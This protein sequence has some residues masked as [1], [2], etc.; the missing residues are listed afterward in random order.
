MKKFA[1]GCKNGRQN[2][3]EK[4]EGSEKKKKKKKSSLRLSLYTSKGEK[5]SSEVFFD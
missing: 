4:V 3:S 5:N 2:E 1:F